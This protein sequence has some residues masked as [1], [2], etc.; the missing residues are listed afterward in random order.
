MAAVTQTVEHVASLEKYKHGFVT[1]IEQ[2]FAP[3]GLS[4][5]TIRFISAK[6]DEPEWMLE[7]R[8]G[9]FER[10]LAMDEPDW[11]KVSFP[12][13]D[14]Q[15]SFYYAAPRQKAALKSLDEVD[16]EILETYKKLG[17]PLREQ[18]VLAGVEGAPKYAV[19]AVFDSVSVVT[20]FKKELAQAGVIFC[21]MS[22]AIR[23]HPE[24]VKQYLGSVVPVSDNFFAALNSAV[25]TDGSFCYV[26]KG[27]RCPMEL[28]TYFRI[29]ARNTGQFERTL[30]IAD[31]GS[32]VSYL[33]GCTA[34][35][36][37]ENQLHAA[38][39]ELVALDD[40]EIKYSTVQ[41][42]YPGDP[43][44]G[45]G[46][47]Y[48]FVTKRADCRGDRSKVSWTQVETGSAI[49]WKYPSCVLRGE[50]SSGEFYSIAITNGRQQADTG[51]KM[52]HLGANTRSR[53]ISKGISAGKSSNTYRGLVSAHPKAKGARNF[54]Q[55]DSL[56]IGKHCAAHT[57]PYI[58]ARN[59]QAKF[60]HEATTTRLS[61]D[62]LFY[63]M[64]RGLSQEEAVQLLVNGFVKDV[65]QELPM[66]FAV[67][68]QKLVAISLEGS[69]G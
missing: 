61:E 37:D 23:E 47:I 21:S 34:P 1:D 51:T 24:L 28:S 53:I 27:V 52:I 40:A 45:K 39:V 29:N 46:G 9:A 50:G 18:E 36:R 58:E 16:P 59:G 8:L 35:M 63:V 57:V 2:D 42:W 11:A 7:W 43:E 41:N 10:W 22:E 25:F 60:E 4:A 26:P 3:K 13:I 5:D 48:N 15:D 33:E 62:Q 66:E 49:T 14:Y 32:Y 55:C 67:E 20:T 68:A 12:K 65:L 69:V 6:K 30:I 56:L 54:T 64:Q 19:D 38:V 44:T 17:I 31:A